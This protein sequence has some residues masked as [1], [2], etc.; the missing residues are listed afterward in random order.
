VTDTP[1]VAHGDGSP[2]VVLASRYGGAAAVDSSYGHDT[3]DAP[4]G[5]WAE[6][7]TVARDELG[8]GYF[9]WLTAVDQLDAAEDPGFDVVVYLWSMDRRAHLLRSLHIKERLTRRLAARGTMPTV[10]H[11]QGAGGDQVP[12]RIPIGNGP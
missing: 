7:M 12:P 11:L 5:S 4:R 10:H 1:V 2:A 6:G 3:V 9:D 8:F